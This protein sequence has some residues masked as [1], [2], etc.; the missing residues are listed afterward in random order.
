VNDLLDW[1]AL[2][3]ALG[4]GVSAGV[5]QRMPRRQALMGTHFLAAL[6]GLVFAFLSLEWW[7]V[8]PIVGAA[9]VTM[10]AFRRLSERAAPAAAFFALALAYVPVLGYI[11]TLAAPLAGRR[12]TKR[13]AE[14]YAGLRVLAKD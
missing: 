1:Y 14:R 10:F 4:I 3:I 12:L 9:A 6:P 7:A 8:F 11:E 5:A 2:G 13:A